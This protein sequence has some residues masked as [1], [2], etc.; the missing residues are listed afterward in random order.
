MAQSK[1]LT[2]SFV[3]ALAFVTSFGC[4]QEEAPVEGESNAP[5]AKSI[6]TAE[7]PGAEPVT[8]ESAPAESTETVEADIFRAPLESELPEEKETSFLILDDDETMFR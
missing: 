7:K 4:Q 8:D 1:I 5:K 2:S 6:E 3:V